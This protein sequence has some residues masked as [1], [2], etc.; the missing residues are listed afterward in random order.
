MFDTILFIFNCSGK[1]EPFTSAVC[2]SS[3]QYIYI[4]YKFI[5]SF[6]SAFEVQQETKTASDLI[7]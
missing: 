4:L 1:I 2:V 7:K 3:S 6:F 5:S